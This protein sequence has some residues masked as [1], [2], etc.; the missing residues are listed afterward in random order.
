MNENDVERKGQTKI[1]ELSKE[2]SY[3]QRKLK[4]QEEIINRFISEGAGVLKDN[5]ARTHCE[6]CGTELDVVPCSKHGEKKDDVESK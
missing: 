2:L 6:N 5:W 1:L 3:C 4:R